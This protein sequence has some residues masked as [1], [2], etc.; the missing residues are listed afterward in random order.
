MDNNIQETLLYFWFGE[1]ENG[2]ATPDKNKLWYLSSAETDR[3]ITDKYA[4]LHSQ[5]AAK[6]L[7]DWQ[8]APRGSLALIILLDQLSR[9]IFRGKA[10]AFSYDGLALEYCIDGIDKGYDTGLEITEQLFYY[11]PLMH[12]EALEHQERCV[13]LF[14]SMLDQCND[15]NKG[16]V[17]NSVKFAREHRDIIA[18][19][20]RFPYR[21]AVLGRESTIKE[22]EYLGGGGKRFGQ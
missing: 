2:L 21:N 1:I 11:H 17:E 12:A 4:N 16:M 18:E 10:Q 13:S 7:S 15:R 22:Q 8:T 20:G 9:N 19:Y 6:N 14:E 3:L 5:A